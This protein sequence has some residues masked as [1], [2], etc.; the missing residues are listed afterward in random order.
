M[1]IKHIQSAKLNDILIGLDCGVTTGVAILKKATSDLMLYTMDFWT[2]YEFINEKFPVNQTGVFIEAPQ[3]IKPSFKRTN[4]IRKE[5][6]IAQNVGGV[7]RETELMIEGMR[8]SGY[9]VAEI[10]PKKRKIDHEYF[11]KLTGYKKTKTTNQHCRDA[12]MLIYGL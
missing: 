10:K 4:N 5:K 8:R 9:V 1:N 12:A 7:K 11:V 2:A 3:Y 6:K